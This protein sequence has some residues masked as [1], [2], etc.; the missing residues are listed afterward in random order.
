MSGAFP[1]AGSTYTYAQRALNAHVGFLAGWAMMLD[2]FLIPLLSIIYAALT[3]A[4]LAPQ[5]PYLAMGG[6]VH[7]GH[8]RRQCPRHSS[9]D[10][11]QFR[12]DDHHDRLRRAVC[13]PGRTLR[14]W[15]RTVW[16]GLSRP[17][18]ILAVRNPSACAR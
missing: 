11:R 12:D 14:G 7:R 9:Y 15:T 1:A 5:V 8:H 17:A 2:Y 13:G 6:S 16:R 10:P 4:R 3:A 18:G